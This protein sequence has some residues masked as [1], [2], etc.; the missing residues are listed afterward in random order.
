MKTIFNP[1]SHYIHLSIFL[2]LYPSLYIPLSIS[3]SLYPSP[4]IPVVKAAGDGDG[5]EG[6]HPDEDGND[7]DAHLHPGHPVVRPAHAQS[8]IVVMTSEWA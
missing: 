2:S 1:P 4:T 8:V 6:G 7:E 5:Q 3:L